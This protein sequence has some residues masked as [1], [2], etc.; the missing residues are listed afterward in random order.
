MAKCR[1]CGADAGLMFSLCDECTKR[2]QQRFAE[3]AQVASESGKI[4]PQ[5]AMPK[6]VV[7]GFSSALR[8]C[9]VI[10]LIAGVIAGL[11]ILNNAPPAYREGSGFY[12]GLAVVVA[13][14]GFFFFVLFNVIAEIAE[15]LRAILQK[16]PERS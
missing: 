4:V 16:L 2:E 10:D 13:F 5:V 12:V 11:I 6:P 9:G 15:S 14:Q 1:R 8:I 3:Q 7:S